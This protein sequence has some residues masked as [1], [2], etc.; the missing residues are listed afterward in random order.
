M[1][2][3][4]F[5]ELLSRNLELSNKKK[6]LLESYINNLNEEQLNFHLNYVGI[7]LEEIKIHYYTN[8]GFRCVNTNE[9]RVGKLPICRLIEKILNDK[10]KILINEK[11][12]EIYH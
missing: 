7:V 9:A 3:E 12:K 4:V 11:F 5:K 8:V 6:T 10:Y 2:A 1:L